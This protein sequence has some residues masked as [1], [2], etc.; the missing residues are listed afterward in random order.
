MEHC[1]HL[2]ALRISRH[3]GLVALFFLLAEKVV[4]IPHHA[5]EFFEIKAVCDFLSSPLI[6]SVLLWIEVVQM[7][8][9]NYS[10]I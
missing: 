1:F 10:K 9:L 6:W 2:I 5:Y 3:F 4:V 7:E 8:L